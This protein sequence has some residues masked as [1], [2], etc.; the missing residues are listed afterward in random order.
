M[1]SIIKKFEAMSR[2][3]TM[4]LNGSVMPSSTSSSSIQQQQNQ[5]LKLSTSKT[6][7]PTPPLALHVP[8]FQVNLKKTSQ[9]LQQIS[10]PKSTD[11]NIINSDHINPK[12]IIERFEQLTKINNN[13]N[14]GYLPSLTIN[15]RTCMVK[16][17][18]FNEGKWLNQFDDNLNINDVF[19]DRQTKNKVNNKLPN[20]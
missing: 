1:K 11:T 10:K 5:P 3:A 2:D 16:K 4:P 7:I 20:I 15:K 14:V 18:F 13:T 9:D 8:V 6:N 17:D 19:F 12:S